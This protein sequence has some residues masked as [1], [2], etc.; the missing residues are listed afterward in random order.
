MATRCLFRMH[1][2]L[3]PPISGPHFLPYPMRHQEGLAREYLRASLSFAANYVILPAMRGRSSLNPLR[4]FRPRRR[5]WRRCG[6]R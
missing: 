1:F 5:S 6:R 2:T 3:L 4:N